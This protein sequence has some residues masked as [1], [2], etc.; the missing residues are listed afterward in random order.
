MTA[1][2]ALGSPVIIVPPVL[3]I[4][5]LQI[6]TPNREAAMASILACAASVVS[7]LLKYV[8]RRERPNTPY[9]ERMLFK[10]YSFPSGHAFSSAVIYGLIVCFGFIYLP[11]A[12]AVPI[13]IGLLVLVAVIGF[14]RVY[15]GAHYV[16]DV[17]G[18]WL[19]AGVVLT[20]LVT[21]L[22]G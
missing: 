6:R 14:S 4:A 10:T 7:A 8:P 5:L 19:F 13:S 1:I 9:V 20:V 16:L 18:G 11:D 17:L 22:V 12:Q 15:L 21:F 2:S 3:I